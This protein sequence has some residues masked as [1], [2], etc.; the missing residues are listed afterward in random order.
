MS[1][2][3]FLRILLA[4]WK[5]ILATAVACF[6]VATTIAM[7]LPKRYPATA[8]VMF[9]A[10]SDPVTGQVLL[11]GRGSTYIGDQ[12]QIIRDM[13]VA[14]AVVDRLGL[15]NDPALIAQFR[16]GGPC[17]VADVMT[18]YQL[19]GGAEHGAFERGPAGRV[20]AC[21]D[22]LNFPGCQAAVEA[23]A[24]VLHPLIA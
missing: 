4:R 6:A 19:V 1:I 18:V 9:E 14:G 13:R 8:R 15:V 20:S 11:G 12:I 10:K 5:L 2:V 16:E 24:V 7:L 17:R 21:L 23:N 3:Q 22:L